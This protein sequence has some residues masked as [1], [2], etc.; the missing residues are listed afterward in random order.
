MPAEQTRQPTEAVIGNRMAMKIGD[1][2]AAL[3]GLVKPAQQA[4]NV[5][6]R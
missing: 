4:D 2:P 1:M 5:F 6:I 3:R